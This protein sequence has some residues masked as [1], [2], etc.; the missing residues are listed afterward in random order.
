MGHG[1]SVAHSREQDADEGTGLED[2]RCFGHNEKTIRA[3]QRGQV[4]RSLPLDARDFRKFFSHAESARR[5]Q[6]TR[7]A[8]FRLYRF[9]EPREREAWSAVNTPGERGQQ[10]R[11]KKQKR[12]CGGDRIARQTKALRAVLV[13]EEVRSSLVNDLVLEE[14]LLR[15]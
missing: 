4:A 15:G 13:M 6:E 7:E 3:R 12:D 2:F 10:R 9:F 5:R 8:A 1:R 14:A 11:G